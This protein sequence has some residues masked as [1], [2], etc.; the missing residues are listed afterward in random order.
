MWDDEP[1]TEN[2]RYYQSI[3]SIDTL[4]LRDLVEDYGIDSTISIIF[5]QGDA[6]IAIGEVE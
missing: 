2:G 4:T 6:F 5:G 1:F 3:L